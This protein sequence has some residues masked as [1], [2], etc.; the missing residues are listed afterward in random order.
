MPVTNLNRL[1]QS[2]ITM[3]I[4]PVLVLSAVVLQAPTASAGDFVDT[5]LTFGFCDDD[6]TK[7][8]GQSIPNSPSPFFGCGG[9]N[10]QFFDNYETKTSGFDNFS[11]LV[12]YKKFD[13]FFEGLTIDAALALRLNQGAL[14]GGNGQLLRDESSYIRLMYRP[15]TWGE[16]DS[17]QLVTFPISADRFR[18]GYSYRL[19]W[20]GNAI[21]P[22]L[23]SAPSKPGFKLQL[24]RGIAEAYVGAKAAQIRTPLENSTLIEQDTYYAVLGGA[25]VA[26]FDGFKVEANGGFFERGTNPVPAVSGAPFQ[27]FGGSAQVSYAKGERVGTSIDFALYRND[28]DA[29]MNFF[30]LEEYPGGFSYVVAAEATA[31]GTTLADP[32]QAGAGSTVVQTGYAGD[33][34][35]RVKY[36]FLR[37]HLTAMMRDLAFL[38][39][40]QGSVTPNYALPDNLAQKAEYFVALGADYHFPKLHFTPGITFGIQQSASYTS[41]KLTDIVGNNPSLGELGRRTVVVREDPSFAGRILQEILPNNCGPDGDQACPT[42]P[43]FGAKLTGR[44]DLAMGVTAAA[45]LFMNHNPNRVTYVDDAFGVAQRTYS[46]PLQVGFNLLT[47]VRF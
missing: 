30:R 39:L 34:Q 14:F 42:R 47:G 10:T 43:M 12:L 36:D 8:A 4:L 13:S 1:L 2:L 24:T 7:G 3:R 31:V 15:Q 32:S 5:R 17:V 18:L 41:D 28:P 35:V 23:T 9:Q 25:S 20:G 16:K 11:N 19:S 33:V 22:T 29:P 27:S 46:D 6:V 21:F 38:T 40:N 37:V 44:F 26:P 45:E